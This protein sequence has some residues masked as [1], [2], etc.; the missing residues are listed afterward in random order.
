MTKDTDK[1]FNFQNTYIDLNSHFFQKLDLLPSTK[2]EMVLLN[3]DLAKELGIN[4]NS[5]D[6]LLQV[7]SGSKLELNSEPIAQAY[8]GHQFGY[9]TM[10]GDGRTALLGEHMD[11]KI[12][13]LTFN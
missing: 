11:E 4:L 13:D 1:I 2:P 6:H 9:F 8:A 7:L 10:L 3:E 12:K 5:S